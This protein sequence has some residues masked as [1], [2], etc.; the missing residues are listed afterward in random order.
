MGNDLVLQWSILIDLPTKSEE[1][2][3]LDVDG[4]GVFRISKK[5]N[6]GQFYVIYIGS[7]TSIKEELLRL[8]K[9]SFLN[10]GGE[11][12]F[13]YALVSGESTRKA[14]EKQM[15]KYYAPMYNNTEPESSVV[16]N[17]NLN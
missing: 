6:D 3:M 16:I 8:S 13:R 2:N 5:E 7:A 4:E 10:Q 9:D 11:F 15:Y 14:I 17:A 1:I 12:S